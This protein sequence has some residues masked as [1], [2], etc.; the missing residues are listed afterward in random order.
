M[1]G[2][3]SVM[4]SAEL[5]KGISPNKFVVNIGCHDGKSHNDPCYPLFQAGYPG[6]AIDGKEMPGVH[7]NLNFDNVKKLLKQFVYPQNV[8]ELLRSNGCPEQFHMLKIDVDGIDGDILAGV[9]AAG[10]RPDF[11]QVEIQPE[12]PPPVVFSVKQHALF[13]PR[14]GRGG[15]YGISISG[16]EIMGRVFGYSIVSIGAGHDVLC[17]RDDLLPKTSFP[18]LDTV[19]DFYRWK[20]RFLHFRQSGIDSTRWRGR[21]D[22]NELLA[23]MFQACI[24]ASQAAYGVA[25]PF[26]LGLDWTKIKT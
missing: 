2:P 11:I 13:M 20:H 14:A 17:I 10:F 5:A 25:L 12:F 24:F 4:V 1:L 6:L 16:V 18:A 26:E 7:E 3:T 15:F 21:Q 22:W 19:T 9:L 8:A 23:E